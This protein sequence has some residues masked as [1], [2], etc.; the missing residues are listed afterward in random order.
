M[1]ENRSNWAWSQISW[2]DNLDLFFRLM[3]DLLSFE[4]L[5]VD[6]RPLCYGLSLLLCLFSHFMA[7]SWWSVAQETATCLITK[8]VPTS[9]ALSFT[10]TLL[11]SI[12]PNFRLLTSFNFSNFKGHRKEV[13][14]GHSLS[15]THMLIVFSRGGNP[16]YGLDR[17]SSGINRPRG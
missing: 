2:N 14:F 10:D 4:V 6:L 9:S 8:N 5:F 12:G 16:I 1:Y 13:C 3:S 7:L 17:F 15:A 11:S